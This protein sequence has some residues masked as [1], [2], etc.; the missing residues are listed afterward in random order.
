MR[1]FTPTV[2]QTDTMEAC[3]DSVVHELRGNKR[4]QRQEEKPAGG[5]S[6]GPLTIGQNK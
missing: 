2:A 4:G 1:K 6:G 5:V 3:V